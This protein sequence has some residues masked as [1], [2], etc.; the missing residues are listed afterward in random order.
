MW[1][2]SAQQ[3]VAKL[4]I[5]F[6]WSHFFLFLS[7]TISRSVQQIAIEY[8]RLTTGDHDAGINMFRRGET[9]LSADLNVI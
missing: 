2:M 7:Q 3:C 4:P 5:L 6:F 1:P 9:I 8:E